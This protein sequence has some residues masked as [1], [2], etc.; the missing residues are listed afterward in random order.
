MVG[1]AQSV[2]RPFNKKGLFLAVKKKND[3]NDKT[4]D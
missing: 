3:G 1:V 2:D 4:N